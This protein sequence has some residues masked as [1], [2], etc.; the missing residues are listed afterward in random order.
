[1]K[2]CLIDPQ[3]LRLGRGR[4]GSRFWFENSIKEEKLER[5]VADGPGIDGSVVL[6]K[7]NFGDPLLRTTWPSFL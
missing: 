5:V 3:K 4:P 2:A 7:L 1:M 6:L